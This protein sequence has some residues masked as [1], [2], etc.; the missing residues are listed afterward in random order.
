MGF[1][2]QQVDRMTFAQFACAASGWSRAH[3]GKAETTYPSDEEFED[4]IA[5][6][7]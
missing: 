6:L 1:T 3:G 2:P 7:H 4:A 5:R